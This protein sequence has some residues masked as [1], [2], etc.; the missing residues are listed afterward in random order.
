M[1]GSLT[2]IVDN[3]VCLLEHHADFTSEFRL[4]LLNVYHWLFMVLNQKEMQKETLCAR[5]GILKQISILVEKAYVQDSPEF[6]KLL[7]ILDVIFIKEFS[8][9]DLE[10]KVMP[11]VLLNMSLLKQFLESG[12]FDKIESATGPKVDK[13][14]R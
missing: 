9:E 11:K 5:T 13:K 3:L 8:K 14:L 7:R 1:S 4:E 2:W 6:M 10:V 12:G